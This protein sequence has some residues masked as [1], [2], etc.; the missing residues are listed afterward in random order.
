MTTL[1]NIGVIEG[2]IQEGGWRATGDIF[3]DADR[4]NWYQEVESYFHLYVN[5]A[6][7]GS[8]RLAFRGHL[9][10][11][12]WQKTFQS[13]V[14]PWTAFTAQEFMKRGEIQGIYF[15]EEASPAN[16][17]QITD[18]QYADIISHIIG[19]SGEF[20]HCN[21]VDSVWPE[22]FMLTNIDTANSAT[23]DNHEIKEGNYWGRIQEI[24]T[25][26]IYLAYLSSDGTFNYI[27]HP[28][29]QASLPSVVFDIDSSWLLEPL[30]IE[31]RNT[32]TIG[33]V[34]VQGA[35]SGGEQISG[36]YPT[37][38]TA[39]PVMQLAG[40]KATDATDMATVAERKYKYLNRDVSVTARLPG[41][42]GLMIDLMDR[43]SITYTSSADGATWS[44]KKF[45]V[46][47]IRV[48]MA[49]SFVADPFNA[50]TTLSL[51]AENA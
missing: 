40:F 28:M 11:E 22:G 19:Q 21:L 29:F 46:E 20:G 51:E 50:V 23:P 6:W 4:L 27:R 3:G 44:A 24:A 12:P 31:N 14:T 18:M 33:Q 17:H 39:G 7:E 26:E 15:K 38:P 34:R 45:W 41:A 32:E 37:E 30:R 35:T 49:D 43:L 42:V 13:S 36:K 48:E 1:D 10:P 2:S 16:E 5:G 8:P 47:G 25:I 9:L